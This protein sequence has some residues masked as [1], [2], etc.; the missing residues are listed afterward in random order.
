MQSTLSMT[1]R[2]V[3]LASR[4]LTLAPTLAFT[5]ALALAS[6]WMLGASSAAHAQTTPPASV[7]TPGKPAPAGKPLASTPVVKSGSPLATAMV[8][9]KPLWKDLTSS[10]Q[11][12]L[13]PLAANWTTID[14]AQKRKWL[15]V[16]NSY[17][18]LP[19]PEQQKMHSR[20]A[21]WSNLSKQQRDQARLNFAESKKLA[22]QE[23][24]EKAATWEAYQALS[25]EE[26]QKLAAKAAP[27][28]AGAA[29]A[30]KPMP[31]E[32][33]ATVPSTRLSPKSNEPANRLSAVEGS[34][35]QPKSPST[36][37]LPGSPVQKN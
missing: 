33:L 29:V 31:P 16:S 1:R 28:P 22:P 15:A 25:P 17:A 34:A 20:M 23:K 6:L 37:D 7:P 12:A 26:K 5:L 32:K 11:A 24:A 10:Q 2:K 4:A 18:T 13:K 19:P 14:E 27:K 21:E 36:P 3:A 30:A 35:L 9:T 8:E